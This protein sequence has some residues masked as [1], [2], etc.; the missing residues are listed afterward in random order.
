MFGSASS[1]DTELARYEAY[2]QRELPSS[3]R[4]EL[5]TRVDELLENAEET[6][7]S[8]LPNIFRDIQIRHFQDY[9]QLQTTQSA[10]R[11]SVNSQRTQII[12]T[13][14]NEG[15]VT[16]T[17]EGSSADNS[18][19]FI[20]PAADDLGLWTWENSF[21][22]FDGIL[23]QMAPSDVI[24]FDLGESTM[25]VDNSFENFSSQNARGGPSTTSLFRQ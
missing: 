18:D 20:Q 23:Y 10:P 15:N 9:L 17:V 25:L 1:A 2:L 22:S 8:Q 21:P 7:R 4:Q 11:P 6:L 12:D 24:S 5:E 3:I 14:D 13:P 19:F 16:V